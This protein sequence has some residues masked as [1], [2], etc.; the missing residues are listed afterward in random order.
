MISYLKKKK[1]SEKKNN[2]RTAPQIWSITIKSPTNE[3]ATVSV[4]R[5]PTPGHGRDFVVCP[6]QYV[7]PVNPR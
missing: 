6:G 7:F 4:D 1:K 2:S 3:S 5:I